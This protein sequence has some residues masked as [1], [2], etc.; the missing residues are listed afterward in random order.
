MG[1][2]RRV[3]GQAM[4]GGKATRYQRQM[5]AAS[6]QQIDEEAQRRAEYRR[7]RQ[8]QGEKH[9]ADFGYE[10]YD[11]TSGVP[12]KRGW[13]FNMLPTVRN[14]LSFVCLIWCSGMSAV[15]REQNSLL[16]LFLFTRYNNTIPDHVG[17]E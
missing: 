16:S 9:D 15:V 2:R 1:G 10:R 3:F 7:K 12:Q 17:L 4:G 14:V 11:R 6:Y 5:G 13:L 8:E